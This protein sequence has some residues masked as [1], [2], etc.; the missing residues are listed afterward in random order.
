MSSASDG[1]SFTAIIA[2]VVIPVIA[3]VGSIIAGIV[4]VFT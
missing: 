1:I 3:V 2:A 4:L